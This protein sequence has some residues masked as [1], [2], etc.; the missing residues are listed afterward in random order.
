[1]FPLEWEYF[2]T[3]FK[4]NRSTKIDVFKE[5]VK[6]IKNKSHFFSDTLEAFEAAQKLN[7]KEDM[8]LVFGSFFLLEEII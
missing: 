2:F 6:L 8:L 1:M 7:N 4:N 3:E 5:K